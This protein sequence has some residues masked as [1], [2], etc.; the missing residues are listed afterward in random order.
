[1]KK[2]FL[3][4]MACTAMLFTACEG[5]GINGLLGSADFVM[6]TQNGSEIT[7]DTLKVK[8]CVG[9]AFY[10]TTA[11]GTLAIAANIDLTSTQSILSTPYF[12]FYVQD[13]LTQAYTLDTLTPEYLQSW[14][15][16]FSIEK[17]ISSNR[18]ILVESDTSWVV[19]T[20]GNFTIND[21]ENFGGYIRASADNARAFRLTQTLLDSLSNVT[22][23]AQ[24]GDMEAIMFL[25]GY[26]PEN[27][28]PSV[29]ING[30]I[31]SRR[32]NINGLVRQIGE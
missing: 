31:E 28:F 15:T 12:A 17:L 10:D 29:T 24:N 3:S 5:F 19:S 8:S 18:I 26:R 22:D 14:S 11:T 25:Q 6:T 4:L 1:M 7:V 30:N 9:D 20:G 13:T 21:F 2:I 27:F 32:M 16:G 23:R